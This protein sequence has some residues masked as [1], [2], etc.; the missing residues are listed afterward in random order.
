MRLPSVRWTAGVH[1]P[2]AGHNFAVGARGAVAA[3]RIRARTRA[4]RRARG[5][6]LP[7]PAGEGTCAYLHM[8]VLCEVLAETVVQRALCLFAWAVQQRP[9]DMEWALEASGQLFLLQVCA[10]WPG[11][12]SARTHGRRL[13]CIGAQTRPVTAFSAR[14]AFDWW[15]A[16]FA[17]V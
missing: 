15:S 2:F 6:V 12:R 8:H 13:T 9:Q 1:D 7:P 5:V 4:H 17:Q 16:G 10:V 3:R 14:A 11:V